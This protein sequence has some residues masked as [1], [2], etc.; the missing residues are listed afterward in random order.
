MDYTPYLVYKLCE[1]F[2]CPPSQIYKENAGDI[3]LAI[4][5]MEEE[6]KVQKSALERRK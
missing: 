6:A 4:A 2:G 5:F 3:E 1:K